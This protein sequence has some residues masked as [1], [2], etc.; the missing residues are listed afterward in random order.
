[1]LQADAVDEVAVHLAVFVIVAPAGRT[2]SVA[3]V[4][5]AAA[6][7]AAAPSVPLLEQAVHFVRVFVEVG[8]MHTVA[9]G[10]AFRDRM[11]EVPGCIEVVPVV[12]AQVQAEEQVDHRSRSGV[13]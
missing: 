10:E 9:K 11:V 2:V 3:V 12:R 4:E 1:M 8:M 6:A 13:A 5:G 7:V